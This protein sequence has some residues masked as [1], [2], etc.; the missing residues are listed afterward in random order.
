[1]N[2]ITASEGNV[3]DFLCSRFRAD[4]QCLAPVVPYDAIFDQNVAENVVCPSVS[5]HRLAHRFFH[6]AV[7]KAVKALDT[8]RIVIGTQEA[9][10]NMNV[11]TV[12]HIDSVGVVS[13]TAYY[14]YVFE[15]LFS[16]TVYFKTDSFLYLL[17]SG[18]G[19]FY[20]VLNFV[21]FIP[22]IAHIFFYVSIVF[23]FC[24][25]FTTVVEVFY[26]VTLTL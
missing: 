11:N 15:Q 18:K 24:V 13:P 3:V 17:A 4:F 20:T 6:V 12:M 10:G 14:L 25:T 2:K 7:V 9:V 16:V 26:Y 5:V 21:S 19:V 8:D 22:D 1:M 23:I